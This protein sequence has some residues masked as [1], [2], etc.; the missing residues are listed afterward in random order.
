[1]ENLHRL[2][3]KLEANLRRSK[4]FGLSIIKTK[5]NI[6]IINKIRQVLAESYTPAEEVNRLRK[7]LEKKEIE[8]NNIKNGIIQNDEIVKMAHQ[9]ALEIESQA[10]EEAQM[11]INSA[12]K[13]VIKVLQQ[14]EEE[15]KRLLATVQES[16]KNL[17][18]EMQT[19]INKVGAKKIEPNQE[20]KKVNIKLK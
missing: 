8:L 4:I 12:E 19:E 6:S 14:F 1:M 7:E 15:L 16:R 9:K 13:Y 11:L 2:I 20:I 18:A 10:K 3:D 17:E 5:E